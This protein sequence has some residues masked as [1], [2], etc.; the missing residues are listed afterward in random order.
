MR[1]RETRVARRAE[2]SLTHGGRAIREYPEAY[3]AFDVAKL[4]HAVAV[5]GDRN[6]EVRFLGEMLS[7]ETERKLPER[8]SFSKKRVKRNGRGSRRDQIGPGDRRS[9]RP[10]SRYSP[11]PSARTGRLA[12]R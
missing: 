6:G 1:M 12:Y 8:D 2:P 11:S 7:G 9:P 3:V 4:K 5:E 10:R